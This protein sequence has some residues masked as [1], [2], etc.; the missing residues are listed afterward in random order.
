V[1]NQSGMCVRKEMHIS[2]SGSI[3]SMGYLDASYRANMSLDECF[4]VVKNAVAMAIARDGSSGGCIRFAIVT[5]KGV[6]KR[7]IT[8]TEL[9]RFNEM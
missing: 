2:G 6:E 1:V 8:N 9:P 7:L 5:A 3:Y 4:N